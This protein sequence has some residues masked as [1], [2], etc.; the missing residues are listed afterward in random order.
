MPEAVQSGP[1][2][3]FLGVAVKQVRYH[4][5]VSCFREAV[6]HGLVEFVQPAHMEGDYHGWMGTGAFGKCSVHIH[7]AAAYGQLVGKTRHD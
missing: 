2:H 3:H 1:V 7:L 5:Y 4:G 6:S